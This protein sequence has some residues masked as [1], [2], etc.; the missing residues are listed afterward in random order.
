MEYGALCTQSCDPL[1]NGSF[2]DPDISRTPYDSAIFE[3]TCAWAFVDGHGRGIDQV[4]HNA[5]PGVSGTVEEYYRLWTAYRADGS[6]LSVTRA[7]TATT[8]PDDRTAVVGSDGESH[9]LTRTFLYDS[10]GRRIAGTDP[11]SDGRGGTEDERRWRYLYSRVGDLVAVR[12]PRGCGA[13]FYYDRAGRLLGEDYVTCGEAQHSFEDPNEALPDTGAVGLGNLEMPGLQQV[14]ARYYFDVAPSFATGDMSPPSGTNFLG[15]LTGSSDRGQR[16]VV[17]YDDRGRAYWSARQMALL[18]DALTIPAT[19]S[20]DDP[21]LYDEGDLGSVPLR[22][23]D[24]EHTYVS[25]TLFNRLDMVVDRT[26]PT[27]PD[28]DGV[29][30]APVVRG[31]MLYNR[32]GLPQRAEVHLDSFSQRVVDNNY[33]ENGLLHIAYFGTIPGTLGYNIYTLIDY[34]E[35]LR[36][37]RWRHTRHPDLQQGSLPELTAYGEIIDNRY[38][39]DA[40]NNLALVQNRSASTADEQEARDYL[41]HQ[42]ALYRVNMIEYE[43]R[44]E[45]GTPDNVADATD[46]R[47]TQAANIGADPM[48]RE[49]APMLPTMEAERVKTLEYRHD[50]LANQVSWIDDTLGTSGEGNSFYERSIGQEGQL[51]NGADEDIGALRPAALYFS[52]QLP[53]SA[54]S[55]DAGIDRGGWV[56]LEYGES[57]NV[58]EMT[59]RARC[60]DASAMDVCYDD[61]SLALSS[62]ETHAIAH[63]RCDREQHYQYRW[64]ELNRLAEARRYDRAGT[65]VW[66]LE[67]RQRY[68]YDAGNVRTVKLTSSGGIDRA[69]LYVL[70]GD[71]ER[72]GVAV[73]RDVMLGD[74]WRPAAGVNAESQYL[75]AGARVV[76]KHDM[77]LGSGGSGFETDARITVPLPDLL[78]T[79]V[80]TVD[81]I[82]GELLEVGTFYPSGNRETLRGRDSSG[83]GQT[84]QLEPMGFTGKEGD[85]EVGLVYFGERYLMPHL[86]RWASADPL[87]VHAGGGGE[88]GNSFHYVAG[89]LLQARDP[90]GLDFTEAGNDSEGNAQFVGSWE[91]A[92][93]ERVATEVCSG[94]AGACLNQFQDQ[95]FRSGFTSQYDALVQAFADLQSAISRID[96]PNVR[97]ML[98]TSAAQAMAHGIAR[99]LAEGAARDIA[100]TSLYWIRGMT[101][102]GEVLQSDYDGGRA[103]ADLVIALL[104]SV[105]GRALSVATRQGGG[106]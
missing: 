57:G 91:N 94:A 79:T 43:Y 87:Q 31:T 34:D 7:E 80:A 86:G 4:L 77:P 29:G 59:V 60:H 99:G 96:D 98:L 73:D 93:G 30:T 63:C 104:G 19:L 25:T 70:P 17:D 85:D 76:W 89:N 48:R 72:R 11:D 20:G 42:D 8:D 54:P 62:R 84:F 46:W 95:A 22:E 35:R 105:A 28:W 6:V 78:Q 45:T 69:S 32:R 5:R 53:T 106:L 33:D 27:D 38:F 26:Y 90:T 39:W 50:W 52:A 103:T 100:E 61:T 92:Q 47:D 67:A 64:D 83:D 13:N 41:V 51:V 97:A 68:R 14:D 82:S 71:F 3:D 23:W 55:F 21:V 24:T 40:A 75:V 9:T 49:P 37:T 58:E 88:F 65:G 2:G 101:G 1:D 16:S 12:D 102:A 18:P 36:P 15:R 10:L 81:L 66:T 56:D 44:P 74:A